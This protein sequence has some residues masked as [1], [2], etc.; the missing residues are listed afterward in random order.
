MNYLTGMYVK[1]STRVGG[2]LKN[3]RGSQTLEWIGIAAVIVI[4]VGLVSTAFGDSD[5][6]GTI[7]EKFES[8]LDKMIK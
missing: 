6:G 3:E 5:L 2:L 8:L 4:L 7:I 1:A